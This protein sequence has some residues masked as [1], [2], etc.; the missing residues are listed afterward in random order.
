MD[1]IENDR[2]LVGF[3]PVTLEAIEDRK[4]SGTNAHRSPL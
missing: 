2:T 1:H 3:L 4:A